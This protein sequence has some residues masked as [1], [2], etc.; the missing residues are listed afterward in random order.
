MADTL[1]RSAAQLLTGSCQSDAQWRQRRRV[2]SA[3][4]PH[5][6]PRRSRALAFST[7]TCAVR[8]QRGARSAAAAEVRQV[9]RFA[10]GCTAGLRDS[11]SRR[12]DVALTQS[13]ATTRRPATT[14]PRGLY[15]AGPAAA[16]TL[17]PRRV[18]LCV[19]RLSPAAV[20]RPLLQTRSDH[21]WHHRYAQRFTAPGHAPPACASHTG[22]VV[23]R[24]AV[25]SSTG[26][27]ASTFYYL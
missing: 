10:Y 9:Q 11:G 24:L 2:S 23:T 19:P 8:G 7:C 21:C 17:A 4:P 5:T 15:A 22:N 12:R 26:H 3:T 27:D 6:K 14:L 16:R 13:A 20:V 1:R 18:A 25:P